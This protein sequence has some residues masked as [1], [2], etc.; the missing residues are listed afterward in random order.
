MTEQPQLPSAPWKRVRLGDIVR[1]HSGGTPKRDNRAYWGG[2]IPWFSGKDLKTFRLSSAEETLTEL[3]CEAGS[4][5]VPAGSILILV[6]GM[7]LHKDVPVGILSQP[8]AFNQDLKALRVMNGVNSDYLGHWLVASKPRLMRMVESSGH[9]TGKLLTDSLR[10]LVVLIPPSDQQQPIA[11]LFDCWEKAHSLLV[12]LI[13][14]KERLRLAL[15]QQ[16]FARRLQFPGFRQHRWDECSFGALVEKFRN[17]VE[18]DPDTQHCEIG[19]RSHGKGIFHKPPVVGSSL[20]DKSVFWVEP[21]CLVFNIV[22]AWEQAVA[23]TSE[24]ERGMIASHRF[25]MFKPDPQ[26]LSL[27]YALLYLTSARGRHA[28]QLASP[29]G[30]GRNRT[31]SQAELLRMKIPLP[32][33]EEQEKI[34]GAVDA[35]DAEI[36]ALRRYLDAL[37]RQK[38]GLMQK[39]LGGE[40]PIPS[41]EGEC[42]P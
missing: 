24:A 12:T 17:P 6:R 25:P 37:K 42:A 15:A 26:R 40:F 19:V 34:A 29:G 2:S 11:D 21:G 18:V 41:G 9:G 38:R 33:I 35:T 22:F 16:L 36:A 39:L 5:L 4:Q 13:R 7:T 27:R 28:L 20:G 3:G 1:L 31:L 30:A 14:R 10:D 23:I 32:C 8:S